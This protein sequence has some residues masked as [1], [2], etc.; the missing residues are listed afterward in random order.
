MKATTFEITEQPVAKQRPRMTR[1]GR[2]YRPSKTVAFEKAIRGIVAP[3]HG[4]VK[5]TVWATF[6][7]PVSWTK[8]KTAA[9]MNMPHIQRP[10]LDN[11]AKAICDALNGVAYTDDSQIAAIEARKVWG[12]TARTVITIEAITDES[13]RAT[14]PEHPQSAHMRLPESRNEFLQGK[15]PENKKG[16]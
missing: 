4:P 15:T 5:V 14:A 7:P 11:V 3:L 9:K 2:V 8:K 1:N 12:P 6:K 16:A 13:N 10:D